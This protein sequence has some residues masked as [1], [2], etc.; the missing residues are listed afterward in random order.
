MKWSSRSWFALLQDYGYLIFDKHCPKILKQLFFTYRLTGNPAT[1]K[2]CYRL[3]IGYKLSREWRNQMRLIS[4][5]YC[6]IPYNEPWKIIF[7]IVVTIASEECMVFRVCCSALKDGLCWAHLHHF[8]LC[9]WSFVWFYQVSRHSSF[10][11]VVS[12]LG[13]GSEARESFRE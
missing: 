2:L 4:C 1:F 9:I 6:L 10:F 12:I 5:W 13:H 8:L 11:L 3:H 7:I